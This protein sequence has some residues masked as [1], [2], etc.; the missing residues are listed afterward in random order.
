MLSRTLDAKLP[1]V[2]V[3]L[4][5]STPRNGVPP[6]VTARHL[7]FLRVDLTAESPGPG[8]FYPLLPAGRLASVNSRFE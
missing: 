7:G 2:P 5:P 6:R 3:I 4:H 1:T 8:R